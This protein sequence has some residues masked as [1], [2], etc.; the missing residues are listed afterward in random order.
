MLFIY[1]FD[2][3]QGFLL[4]VNKVAILNPNQKVMEGIHQANFFEPKNVD[5]AGFIKVVNN[6][7]LLGVGRDDDGLRNIEHIRLNKMYDRIS[8]LYSSDEISNNL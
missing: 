2:N 6:H 5:A 3:L 7:V 4:G 1:V 8:I